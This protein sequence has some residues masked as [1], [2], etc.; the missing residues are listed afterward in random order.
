MKTIRSDRVALALTNL[1]EWKSRVQAQASTHVFPLLALLS[2]GVGHMAG[3]VQFNETPSEYEFW[4]RHLRLND[5]DD[6]KPYFNPVTR[7]RA[8]AGFPHSNSATIRKN[9]FALR[10]KG[11][12][13]TRVDE[14]DVWEL[15]DNYADVFRE[16]VLSKGGVV[17]RV[18]IVD[19][20][21]ILFRGQS[22]DDNSTARD[23]ERRF[24]SEFPQR[25][26][27]YDK[28]FVFHD[29]DTDRIF[30]EDAEQDYDDAI[31]SALIANIKTADALPTVEADPV[32]MD[33]GDPILTQVQ[34]LLRFGTSGMILSGPPGT[35]KSYYAKR[36]AK[37]LVSDP[38][39]DI[40]RVQF[41]PSYGYEDFVEG[42]R[43]D[44]ATTS[45][46]RVVDKTFLDA[47][48]RAD[49]IRDA[50]GLVVVVVDEINRGDPARIFGELL[51]YIEQDYRG[52]QFILPF[53]GRY[54][55]V[56]ENLVILGTMNP[57]DRSVAQSDAAFV[58]RFDH[59]SI[60]PSREVAEQLLEDA[61]GFRSEQ[62]EQIGAWFETAQKILPFGLGH[63]YFARVRSIEDLLLVWQY[64]IVPAVN[65]VMQLTDETE[66]D[67]LT[68]SFEAL[69]RRLEGAV[70]D[71]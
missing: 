56:P 21:T 10:W 34:R 62:I 5:G 8:E 16:K 65:V 50:D 49:D 25:D 3:P 60:E 71:A 17:T 59:I 46:Y 47:C 33:L 55:A 63:S 68:N 69:I 66:S 7:R 61:G 4:D 11:A 28:M 38:E 26:S 2:S 31:S 22:F 54:V 64:R 53:S 27:D 43:P 24:R 45:G 57:H 41:H 6:E 14:Q 52:E 40:F 19:V 35:G 51:T 70:P 18:P 39:T 36:I 32:Q 9:S 48:K 58:R 15:N 67:N 13:H 12:V 42:Y 23:L 37:H 30:T 1:A 29:E 44:E 20:A